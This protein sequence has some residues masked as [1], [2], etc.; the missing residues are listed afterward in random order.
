MGSVHPAFLWI[1]RASLVALP[2]LGILAAAACAPQPVVILPLRLVDLRPRERSGVYLNE[3]LVLHFS[4]ELDRASVNAESVRVVSRAGEAARGA[5]FVVGRELTF[6]PDPVCAPDLRDGGYLPNTSYVVELAGFPRSDTL[7]SADGACLANTLRIEF[8]TVAIENPRSGPVFIDDSPEQARPLLVPRKN[9]SAANKTRMQPHTGLELEGEEPIDP[10]SLSEGYF[11]L[12]RDDGSASPASY[13]LHPVLEDNHNRRA[14]HRQGTTRLRLMPHTSLPPGDYRLQ[15]NLAGPHPCDF[16]GHR[17]PMIG[18]EG[19]KQLSIRVQQNSGSEIE[20]E[21]IEEFLDRKMRSSARVS[22]VDG[23]VVWSTTGR[24]EIHFP[25]AAGDGADDEVSFRAVE[26]LTNLAAVHLSVPEYVKTQWEGGDGL[27]VIASQGAID[28]E[29]RLQRVG[30]ALPAA[31]PEVRPGD[32]LTDWIERQRGSA[33]PVTVLVSGADLRISGELEVPG[34]LLLVA[35]GRV[36][37]SGRIRV[38][39]AE[40]VDAGYFQKCS[41]AGTIAVWLQPK[42][43][44]GTELKIEAAGLVL[45]PPRTNTLK[46]PL[47]YAVRSVSIPQEGRVDRW[48]PSEFP[49]GRRG[50]G[51]FQVRYAGERGSPDADGNLELEVDDPALLVDCPRLSLVL[52]LELPVAQGAPWDPPSIDSIRLRWETQ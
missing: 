24:A 48:L 35:G 41:D 14:F 19:P 23:T 9:L 30:A 2:A 25:A 39:G 31:F 37:I 18:Q 28:I 1:L 45:D 40:P 34:P 5:R 17:V 44:R 7:R 33:L 32:T 36:R 15:V 27:C 52:R 21:Y 49:R 50:G 42:P 11:S 38:A 46:R 47:V 43:D 12:V 6:V 16:S 20:S 22:G 8:H 29:G 10:S 4:A 3:P 51:S 26:R 13:P